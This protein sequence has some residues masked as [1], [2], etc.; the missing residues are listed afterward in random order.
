MSVCGV[1]VLVGFLVVLFC[2]SLS[3]VAFVLFRAVTL[4]FWTNLML[5]VRF[6]LYVLLPV[7]GYFG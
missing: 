6:I 5:G 7:V 2:C 3:L 4:C 1:V